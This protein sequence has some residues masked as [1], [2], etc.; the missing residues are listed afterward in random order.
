MENLN[1]YESIAERTQGDIYV[2]VVGPVRTGK[3]TFIK[4]FMDL[5]VIPNVTNVYV[6]ERVRDELPQSGAGRTITTTEPKFVPAEAVSLELPGNINFKVRMVDCVG[7]MVNS[8]LGHQENGKA[9]MVSTPWQER[10]IPFEE[11]AEIGTKKVITDHSTIGIVVTTDGTI[12]EIERESYIPAEERVVRELKELHKPFIIVLNS[13]KPDEESAQELKKSMEE[14]YRVPV[15]ATNCARMNAAVLNTIL[16]ETLYEFPAAQIKF[17]LPGFIDGLSNDH[18]IKASIIH[19]IKEWS[20]SFDNIRD[21]KNSIGLLADGSIIQSM[22]VSSMDLGTGDIDVEVAAVNGLFYKVI[23]E[24]MGEE[25]N[26]DYQFFGLI[27]EFAQAK[28]SYDKLRTAMAQV[29]ESGYGIVQPKLTEMVLEEPEIFKQG[30]KFGVRLKAKAPSLHIIKTDITT[31]VSPVV[32]SEKQSED[33][34]RYLLTEFESDPSKIWETNIFGKSLYEMV[35]EQMENKLSNVPEHIRYKVQ[36]SLQKI[37]DE[38]KEYFICI[39][40]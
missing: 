19:N 7:Y 13:T 30:N 29:D 26:N 6:K 8:A 23:E 40:L 39:V 1:I 17:H 24:I 9:R 5:L 4:R 18:W 28:R 38:G 27:K 37:S 36:R 21:I 31:E 33:L 12:G 32:G 3:S 14:K 20:K 25:V 11:A 16:S 34:I 10:Q 2:G 35:T 15:I 22:D